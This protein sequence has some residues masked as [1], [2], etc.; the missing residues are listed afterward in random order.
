[1]PIFLIVAGLYFMIAGIRGS[2][3]QVA[4]LLQGDLTGQGSFVAW[5]LAILVVGAVGYVDDLQPVSDS[6]LAL[7]LVVLL[8]SNGGFFTKFFPALGVAPAAG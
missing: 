8:L 3:D 4:T 1:M 2:Q 5:I 6:F 7:L